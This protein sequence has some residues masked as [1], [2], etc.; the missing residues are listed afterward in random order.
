MLCI[1][2][3]V[4]GSE[5]VQPEHYV[6]GVAGLQ[7]V[8]NCEHGR[9]RWCSTGANRRQCRRLLADHQV[10]QEQVRLTMWVV[11]DGE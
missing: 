11:W 5:H 8:E 10:E 3:V 2:Q 4:G 9:S 7:R 1:I 6:P